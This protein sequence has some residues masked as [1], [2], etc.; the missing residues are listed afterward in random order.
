MPD[1]LFVGEADKNVMDGTHKVSLV[2]CLYCGYVIEKSSHTRGYCSCKN[3]E[4]V[5]SRWISRT[6]TAGDCR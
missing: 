2:M 1:Y 6:T 5:D 4:F 3:Y